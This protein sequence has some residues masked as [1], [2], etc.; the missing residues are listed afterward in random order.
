MGK[1]QGREGK[2]LRDSC[3]IFFGSAGV[4][5]LAWIVFGVVAQVASHTGTL[6]GGAAHNNSAGLWSFQLELGDFSERATAWQESG[7]ERQF[8]LCN[9]LQ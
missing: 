7:G 2:P 5:L 6:S 3:A 4:V 8:P 9:V 1:F